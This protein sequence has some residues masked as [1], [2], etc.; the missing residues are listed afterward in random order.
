MEHIDPAGY[1][2]YSDKNLAA[3]KRLDELN[4]AR[5]LL[6]DECDREMR[7][8]RK[9]L[10]KLNSEQD[11]PRYS[12]LDKKF[13]CTEKFTPSGEAAQRHAEFKSKE[14]QSFNRAM[15]EIMRFILS[16]LIVKG[17]PTAIPLQPWDANYKNR[18]V[19]ELREQA[20]LLEHEHRSVMQRID[21]QFRQELEH[22]KRDW[23]H[24]QHVKANNLRRQHAQEIE[25]LRKTIESE[26]S[27]KLTVFFNKTYD[28]KFKEIDEEIKRIIDDRNQQKLE[29]ERR[30][31]GSTEY[32]DKNRSYG[33]GNR[34]SGYGC[35]YM[36]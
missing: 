1:D 25:V 16:M 27:R 31:Y 2:P 10:Q 24:E 7:R 26:I 32:W 28:S 35:G 17:E 21:Y 23:Q 34:A 29:S 13:A 33:G 18:R 36:Y 30:R 6:E 8:H 5:K 20:T 9:H 11:D 3:S 22:E 4:A 19:Q 14:I 15:F 12:E